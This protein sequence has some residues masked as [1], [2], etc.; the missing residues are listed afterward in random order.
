MGTTRYDLL[1]DLW[2]LEDTWAIKKDKL[3][4]TISNF[5]KTPFLNIDSI[6]VVVTDPQGAAEIHE[7]GFYQA[8][9]TRTLEINNERNPFP[10][11]CV[12]RSLILAAKLD[13]W[14]G[15]RLATFIQKL[16]RSVSISELLQAQ[17]SHYGQMHFS[18]ENINDWL[19]SLQ[20]QTAGESKKVRLTNSASMQM[21]LWR[22]SPSDQ[23]RGPA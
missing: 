17:V 5:L 13:F 11:V 14:I 9:T 15:P 23:A 10:A 20:S 2:R 18:E 12:V 4:P 8:V 21:Q 16:T 3:A 1:F 22:D 7:N 6:A 19:T